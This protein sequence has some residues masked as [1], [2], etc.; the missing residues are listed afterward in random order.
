MDIFQ[1]LSPSIIGQIALKLKSKSVNTGQFVFRAGEIG[2]KLY[3]QRT[4]KSHLFYGGINTQYFRTLKRGDVCGENVI[5]NRKRLNSLKCQTWSEYYVLSIADI[6]HVLQCNFDPW[7][8]QQKWE[9][10]KAIVRCTMDF[11]N[12]TTPRHTILPTPV[13]QRKGALFTPQ[14]SDSDSEEKTENNLHKA[15]SLQSLQKLFNLETEKSEHRNENVLRTF[16]NSKQKSDLLIEIPHYNEYDICY[17]NNN[18]TNVNINNE[19]NGFD[20]DKSGGFGE[21]FGIYKRRQKMSA[22]RKSVRKKQTTKTYYDRNIN[23][24]GIPT[25]APKSNNIRNVSDVFGQNPQNRSKNV[26]VKSQCFEET[27]TESE[28]T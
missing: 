27:A 16:K 11:T 3:I 10:I 7:T 28:Q 20:S 5:I 17:D 26:S 9:K 22:H 13:S 2:N 18:D 4:G 14:M 12:V 24:G 25:T 1:S 19:M 6:I 15:L 8:A 21:Q 23:I